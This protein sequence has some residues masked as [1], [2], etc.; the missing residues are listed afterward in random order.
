MSGYIH[1]STDEL[2]VAFC[3][4]LSNLPEN[5]KINIWKKVI[6]IN[7]TTEPPPAPRKLRRR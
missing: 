3:Q 7:T 5:C 4:A 1:L 6:D 2:R